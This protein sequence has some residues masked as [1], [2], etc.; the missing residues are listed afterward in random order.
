MSSIFSAIG[1][2][3]LSLISSPALAILGAIFF[4]IGI[5]YFW[6]TMLGFTSEFI[7]K[8]G[9]MGLSLLGGSGFVS[10]AMFLPLMGR[11]LEEKGTQV[12]LQ[13]IGILP[14]LLILGFTVLF[15]VYRRK[16][17]VEL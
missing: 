1:I 14:V 11:I 15:L 8:T 3:T 4:A 9:A 5:C 7:P 13:S 6:P 2:Y 17:P 12:A 16:K 10:V